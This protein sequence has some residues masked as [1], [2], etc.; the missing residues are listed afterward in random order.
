M[1]LLLFGAAEVVAANTL[2]RLTANPDAGF[3]AGYETIEL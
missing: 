1:L 3:E 2:R